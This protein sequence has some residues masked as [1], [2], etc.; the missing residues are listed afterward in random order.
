MSRQHQ[1]VFEPHNTSWSG[2][3]AIEESKKFVQSAIR[4]EPI[5]GLASSQFKNY[6]LFCEEYYWSISSGGRLKLGFMNSLHYLPG[7]YS[8]P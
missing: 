6:L 2:I 5:A 4:K 3:G 1:G 8:C 7:E